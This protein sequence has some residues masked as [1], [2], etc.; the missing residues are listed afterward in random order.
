[1]KYGFLLALLCGVT[2]SCGPP[3]VLEPG[4]SIPRRPGGEKECPATCEHYRD[5]GCVEGK[6]SEKKGITCEE[7]CVEHAYFEAWAHSCVQASENCEQA[8]ACE[9]E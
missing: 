8:T 4:A 7:R 3:P 6:P 1:M 9:E 2:V 5:L